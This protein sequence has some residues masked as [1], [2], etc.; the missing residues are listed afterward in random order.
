MNPL[1]SSSSQ[2]YNKI[3]NSHSNVMLPCKRLPT[4]GD[5]NCL[6]HALFGEFSDVKYSFL[7]PAKQEFFHKNAPAVRFEIAHKLF[8]QVEGNHAIY[9]EL[10]SI[11]ELGSASFSPIN[12]NN[13]ALSL[14]KNGEYLG[15]EHAHLIAKAFKL[16]IRV[17]YPKS[18]AYEKIDFWHRDTNTQEV[19]RIVYFN[20]IDHW[21]KC[22]LSNEPGL[23]SSLGFIIQHSLDEST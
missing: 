19:D 23:P 18:H 7:E 10:Y 16:N 4:T 13:L 21:E 12:I 11:D 14:Q 8:N 1:K 5:G 2:Q 20:G 9:E 17:Y 6:I 15:L 3:D 22:E